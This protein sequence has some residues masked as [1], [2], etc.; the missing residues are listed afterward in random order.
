VHSFALDRSI[1]IALVDAGVA[2]GETVRVTHPLGTVAATTC[3][4]PFVE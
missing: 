3:E 2:I 1:G 4:L